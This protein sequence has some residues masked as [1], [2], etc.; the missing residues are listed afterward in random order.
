MKKVIDKIV[1]FLTDDNFLSFLWYVLYIYWFGFVG[2]MI[3]VS[4]QHIIVKI[5]MLAGD[6]WWALYALVSHHN[7]TNE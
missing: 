4:D 2:R 5:L 6:L 1:E 7:S 3:I